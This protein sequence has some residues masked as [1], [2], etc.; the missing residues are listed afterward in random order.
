MIWLDY[1]SM[2][3]ASS[4]NGPKRFIRQN[5]QD[6]AAY[7]PGEQINNA[8]KL[9]TNECPWPASPKV[10]EAIA[11]INQDALRQY[12]SPASDTLRNLAAEHYKCSPEQILVGNGSDDCLTIIYRSICTNQAKVIC[13]WPSYGLYDTLADIQ[14]VEVLHVPYKINL[15]TDACTWQIDP[16]IGEVDAALCLIANPNNPSGTLEKRETIKSIV[17]RF[18]GIVVIDEAY[19]DF[20]QEDEQR[21]GLIS[22]I[23]DYD[24]VVVLRTFSKSFSLAGARV[25]LL[26]SNPT[27]IN[28]FNKVKDSY[29]VNVMSQIAAE[30]ALAD[31]SYHKKIVQ[32]TLDSK[33]WLE[34]ELTAFG[35]QWPPSEGNFILCHVGENAQ[36]IYQQLKDRDILIRWWNTDELRNYVRITAGTPEENQA[37]VD[38]LKEICT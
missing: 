20:A 23:N 13:P 33:A 22:L 4:N 25:G 9:N 27:L 10:F 5:I 15:S 11:A 17:E 2:S 16:H 3:S 21:Q 31:R 1:A 32:Q 7:A 30:A 28:E 26:F 29:N 18:S 34:K 37:L 12:P 24:N 38:A 19:I 36:N 35:W 6:M 8:T 14:N